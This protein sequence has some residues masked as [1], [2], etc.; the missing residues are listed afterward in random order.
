MIKLITRNK[1]IN[2]NTCI[3]K[4]L[5][6]KDL[7]RVQRV[8]R[9]WRYD[10]MDPV[11]WETTVPENDIRIS[12]WDLFSD[13]LIKRNVRCLDIRKIEMHNNMW[14][15]F[16]SAIQKTICLRKLYLSPCPPYILDYIVRN[17]SF[18]KHIFLAHCDAPF[19]TGL[20]TVRFLSTSFQEV[21][22]DVA[23]STMSCRGMV[24]VQQ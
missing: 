4:Y 10:S 14:S 24:K 2:I 8:C 13:F 11:L 18:V 6:F 12:N 21:Y 1:T 22:F 9:T 16:T 7:L 5:G 20:E 19:F 15:S 23:K 17:C 3:F